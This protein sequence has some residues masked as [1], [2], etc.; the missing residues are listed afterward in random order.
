MFFLLAL[1]HLSTNCRFLVVEHLLYELYGLMFPKALDSVFCGLSQPW[2]AASLKKALIAYSEILIRDLAEMFTVWKS[3][4][5]ASWYNFEAGLSS[6]EKLDQI[7]SEG[8]LQWKLFSV[9]MIMPCVPLH[10]PMF[11]GRQRLIWAF[12]H[13]SLNVIILHLG[14]QCQCSPTQLERPIG[15]LLFGLLLFHLQSVNLL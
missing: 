1:G 9:S 8:L 6:G 5:W 11:F 13:S 7:T 12:S 2:K 14:L 15:F 4:L 3:R 10:M